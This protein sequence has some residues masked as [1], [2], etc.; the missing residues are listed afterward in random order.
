MAAFLRDLNVHNLP[1]SDYQTIKGT[2]HDTGSDQPRAV[3]AYVY[4][5]VTTMVEF[6]SS[7]M[8]PLVLD[9]PNQQDQDEKNARAIIEFIFKRRPAKA[10]VILGTV[11]LQGVANPG[12]TVEMTEKFGALEKKSYDEVAEQMRP[13]LNAM[14]S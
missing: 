14:G 11:S 12:W 7:P 1:D 6:S 2:V 10:Q 4:A 13:F 9:T 3:L 5:F 8:C